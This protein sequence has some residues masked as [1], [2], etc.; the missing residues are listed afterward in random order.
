MRE[1]GMKLKVARESQQISIDVIAEKTKI[2]KQHLKNIEE[3]F[4][5]FLP[6]AYIKGMI[7]QYAAMVRLDGKALYEEYQ[8]HLLQE[9]QQETDFQEKEEPLTSNESDVPEQS[10]TFFSNRI[11]KSLLGIALTLLIVVIVFFINSRLKNKPEELQLQSV[12]QTISDSSVAPD[13]LIP[14][15]LPAPR[16]LD[17]EIRA[18]DETW[19]VLTIDDSSRE[20]VTFAPRMVRN[21]QGHKKFAIFL[22][23]AAG[24]EFYLNGEKLNFKG[25]KGSV[26]NLEIT[27]E[28]LI[29]K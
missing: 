13:T 14:V 9:M 27:K 8:M 15:N 12:T 10:S 3:G 17:L 19:L 16:P 20:E 21:W 23:N 4:W 29:R 1:I 28:G 24:V 22:G 6:E 11:Y 2:S 26:V 7:Q 18:V 5:D 25:Q